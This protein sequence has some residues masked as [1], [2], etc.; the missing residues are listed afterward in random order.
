LETSTDIDWYKIDLKK[1]TELDFSLLNESGTHK[2]IELFPERDMNLY[3]TNIYSTGTAKKHLAIESDGTYYIKI[4]GAEGNYTLSVGSVA[5]ESVGAPADIPKH[6]R[7]VFTIGE[8]EVNVFGKK[9]MNDVAPL[10]R[11]GRTMLP[12]R[13]VAEKLGATVGWHPEEEK[14]VIKSATVEIILFINSSAAYVNDEKVLL[15][16]PAF[17]ENG[18]TYTPVRFVA[19][20]L[21]ATVDW[22]PETQQVLIV[23]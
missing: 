14:V 4:S 9:E 3:T 22:L 19:E 5:E 6:G 7:M 11:N 16:S 13:F 17:V 10:L 1:G 15:D 21:G 2:R 12:A 20:R 23:K 8:K 18:R